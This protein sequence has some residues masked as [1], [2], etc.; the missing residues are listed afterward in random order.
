MMIR[1]AIVG[2]GLSG[3]VF[4]APFIHILEGYQLTHVVTSRQ[5]EVN[6][7]YPDVAVI[8]STEALF[9]QKCVDLVIITTPN[10]QHFPMAKAALLSGHHVVTEKPFVIDSKQGK[11]LVQLA[12]RRNRILSV[13]QNRRFDT[14][15]LTLQRLI[16]E[17]RLGEIMQYEAHFDRFRPYAEQSKWRQQDRPGSGILFDLGSH[18]IDQ[19]LMLFG[20]PERVFADLAIQAEDGKTND[21]VHLIFSYQSR[22]VILHMG[23]VVSSQTPHLSVQG[24]RGSLIINQLDPQEG[25]LRAGNLPGDA[26][27]QQVM[28]DQQ[29][30]LNLAQENTVNITPEKIDCQ[31]GD[32]R[33]FYQQLASCIENNTENPVSAKSALK[34]IELIEACY[35]SHAQG[36]WITL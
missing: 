27:W 16:T 31:P 36:R 3:R 24:T 20:Q 32:Y 17:Q 28:N 2:F 23:S 26:N 8:D 13:Y 25:L 6:A 19:A 1:V 4:H 5:Q 10:E 30:L 35:L 15:M 11:E 12:E 18:L 33:R 21:Y 34:T 22:R 29:A 9:K 14:A 7:L